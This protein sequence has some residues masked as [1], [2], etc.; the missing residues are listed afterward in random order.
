VKGETRSE[1]QL[2]V[3]DVMWIQTFSY[4]SEIWGKYA[5]NRDR[6]TYTDIGGRLSGLR[7]R[8][9]TKLHSKNCN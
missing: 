4:E 5:G 6:Q 7:L 3:H 8:I 9:N 1:A 2:N